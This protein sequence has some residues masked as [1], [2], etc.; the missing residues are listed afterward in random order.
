MSRVALI[1]DGHGAG[2][3]RHG[4]FDAS[5]LCDASH[6]L[7][8]TEVPMFGMAYEL[9]KRGHEVSVYSRFRIYPGW[10]NANG[11]HFRDL[12]SPH[13]PCDLAIAFH[14]GRPL[15]RWN[16]K[17]KALLAQCFLLPN[18]PQ[19]AA[20][21][22]ADF[23]DIYITATDHV[24]RHLER[25]YGWPKVHVVPNAWD[26]GTFHPWDPI[27]GR[28]IYTTSLERGF[29]RLLE[30]FP[31]IRERVPEAHIVAFERG[32]PAVDALRANPVDGVTLVKA[33]S[34]NAVLRE[35]SRAAVMPY[36]CDVS[37]PT[38]VFPM[39]ILE[40]CATGVPVVLAPDDSI[41]KLFAGGVLL[42]PS[43]KEYPST[44]LGAFVDKTVA[45]LTDRELARRWS[46]N[47]RD[48]SRDYTF[49][50]TTKKLVEVCGL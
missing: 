29:H 42:T 31:L 10:S 11:V 37:L 40:A 28:L 18:R 8:G 26:L 50:K 36:P 20:Y 3:G 23:A 17:K 49:E 34:R 41:E 38:E 39:T 19:T 47:G 25:S 30:A 12:D 2:W 9:A 32:G 21:E 24:A 22:G 13:P 14:D 6:G 35:L 44:W 43:V 33:S 1:Y 15:D 7:S 27:P 5:A 16:A 4:G 46:A 48:W 45:M